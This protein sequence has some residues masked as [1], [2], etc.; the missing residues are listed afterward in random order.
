MWLSGA[1]PAMKSS[2]SQPD[3]KR[4][5][6]AAPVRTTL[7]LAVSP[8][9]QR[10]AACHECALRKSKTLTELIFRKKLRKMGKGQ[11]SP[12]AHSMKIK[13]GW[14][15]L[16]ATLFKMFG[17]SSAT[18]AAPSTSIRAALCRR[19]HVAPEVTPS[20]TRTFLTRFSPK[21]RKEMPKNHQRSVMLRRL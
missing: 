4:S 17:F 8:S 5:G 16:G 12:G 19:R 9:L 6:P 3:D 21:A 2:F 10:S 15:I 18:P 1:P 14:R 7:H 20:E 13:P 11:G